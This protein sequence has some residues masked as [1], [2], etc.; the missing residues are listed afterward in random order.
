MIKVI[1]RNKKN[2]LKELGH[3]SRGFENIH[4]AFWKIWL[5]NS[6]N[7]IF[8]QISIIFVL[9]VWYNNMLFKGDVH[10]IIA[11][12]SICLAIV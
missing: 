12:K 8:N 9:F 10:D 2:A 5:F 6:T 1:L 3:M 11:L 7:R 4:D